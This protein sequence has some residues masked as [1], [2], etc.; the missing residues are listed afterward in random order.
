MRSST[1]RVWITP[2]AAV[3]SSKKITRLAHSAERAMATDWRCPPDSSATGIDGSCT[4]VTPRSAKAVIV[5]LRIARLFVNTPAA[6]D[7]PTEEH[8]G[9][10]VEVRRQGEVLVH[11]L[12]PEPVGVERRAELDRVP[13]EEDLAVVGRMH[14][15]KD[16]DE[17]RLAGAVVAD[18]AP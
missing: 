13:V 9:G 5:R 15:R 11:R 2:R 10:G 16:L 12:D 14:P 7:L 6:S 17:C 18:Q 1:R 4:V 8:V 3:G